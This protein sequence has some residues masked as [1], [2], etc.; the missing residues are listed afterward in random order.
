MVPDGPVVAA[1]AS[2]TQG[3]LTIHGDIAPVRDPA[4]I[5]SA[6][7]FYVFSTGDGISVR[8]SADLLEWRQIEPVFATKPPWITTTSPSDENHLWAP[9]VSFFGGVY[10]LNYSASRFGSNSSCIG[11]ARSARLEP[12]SWIDDGGAVVCSSAADNYNAIDPVAILDED[13]MPWLAFGS[14]WD[15]I[16]LT[17]FGADGRREGTDLHSLATRS[18]TAVEAPTLFQVGGIYYLFESVDF[19]CLGAAS[20]YRILVGRSANVT[21]PFVDRSGTPLLSGGGTLV[22]EGDDRWRGP[23]HNAILELSTGTYNVYHAYD[24]ASDGVPTLRV[25]ELMF[26]SDGWPVSSGP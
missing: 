8:E 1:D 7:T 14:F 16:K 5:A 22:L 17:S 13:G 2:E 9:H 10:H 25:A 26:S 12:A 21:G 24:A 3:V 11:H 15:G 4:I 20:T 6:T 23:G 19:C 18:N